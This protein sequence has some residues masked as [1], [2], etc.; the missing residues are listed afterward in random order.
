MA[1]PVL[2]ILF[3]TVLIKQMRKPRHREVKEPAR[4]H[5]ANELEIELCPL[6]HFL[7]YYTTLFCNDQEGRRN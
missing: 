1:G 5:T 6:E 2:R 7:N 3:I 4:G